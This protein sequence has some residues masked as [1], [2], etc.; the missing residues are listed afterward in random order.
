MLQQLETIYGHPGDT[1]LVKDIDYISDDY[2]ILLQHAT[3]VALATSGPSGLDCSPRGDRQGELVRIVTPRQIMMP[4]RRGNNRIDSLK[5]IVADPRVALMFLIPGHNNAL[6]LN[7]RAHIN[8]DPQLL[9]S[10]AVEGQYPR[11]V[12][13]IDIDAVYFQCAR[14]MIR[15]ALWKPET[16]V[17]SDEL[18]TAGQILANLSGAQIGGP[19]YDDEWAARAAKTMW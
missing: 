8:A 3:F 6:R 16:Y 17:N 9:K 13:V 5:N 15:S 14:A 2:L 1:S 4:D 11:S 18:P 10:F 19:D 12:I 7:G